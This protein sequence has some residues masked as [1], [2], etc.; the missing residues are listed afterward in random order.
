MSTTREGKGRGKVAGGRRKTPRRAGS[1]SRGADLRRTVL[2][3]VALA[4]KALGRVP[5]AAWVC[6]LIALL[7]AVSWSLITPPFLALDEPDHF[8]YVQTLVQ[9]GRLPS[10]SKSEYSEEETLALED[11]QHNQV[12]FRPAGHT[13]FSS[14]AQE[15]LEHDLAQPLSRNGPG[16]AGVAKSEPPLYYALAAI[17]YEVG[18]SGSILDR[19]ELMR[20]LS[21][22]L[23]GLTALFVY[24]FLREALPRT[25]WAWTV[26]GLG[27]ALAPLLGFAS[28]TVNPDAL[29]FTVSAALFYCLARAF[30]R[31]LS[32]PLALTIGFFTA[33][34]LATKL[35]FVGIAPGI[36]IG[37]IL[38]ARREARTAGR[39]VYLHTLA[40][41]LA[42]AVTPGVIYGLVN[43]F[44][45]HSTFGSVSGGAAGLT[46]TQHS[47]SGAISYVWQFYLPR[48]P[49]MHNDF[50]GLLTTRQIWFRNVV[51][52]YGWGDTPFPAWVYDLA[53]VLVVAILALCAR[54]LF[55]TRASL[56]SR[57]PEL[58]TY[59]CISLGLLLLVGASG[60]LAFPSSAAEF[61]D[62]RYL[63]PLV[64]LWGS[65]LALAARGAG[66][67]WGPVVG[68]LI[69]VLVIAHDLFSQ[70]Q[71]IARYYG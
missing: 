38:L 58:F 41:A 69:V 13:I 12:R 68:A 59:A 43:V 49:F 7:N 28:S 21:A 11:L 9:T 66:R 45:S 4:R 3:R 40:P 50:P 53:L 8:A 31:R 42:I 32:T 52:L 71:V 27:V 46:S 26:G 19:L 14:G 30:H 54:A 20:L 37:L 36:A 64:V 25:R 39:R 35:N 33:V 67:R 47:I 23:A 70:L 10:S 65:I 2:T 18:S 24:L 5:R 34:G 56:R 55:L 22:F 60:Y 15:K 61:T 44:S 6:T 29:L 62:A 16:G 17:P 48:L 51:G 1:A 63:L 57:L